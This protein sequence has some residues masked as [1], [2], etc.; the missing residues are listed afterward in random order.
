VICVAVV[1]GHP[2]FA[3]TLRA[4]LDETPDTQMVAESRRRGR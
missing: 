4:L 1:D 3:V 2:H